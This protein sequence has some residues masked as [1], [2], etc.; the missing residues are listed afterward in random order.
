MVKPPCCTQP[1]GQ[2]PSPHAHRRG[3]NRDQ[4]LPRGADVLRERDAA[5]V[6]GER[7]PVGEVPVVVLDARPQLEGLCMRVCMR[8]YS[9]G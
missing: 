7:A 6:V 2:M 1:P 9:S 4:L 3:E 5:Q 8:V